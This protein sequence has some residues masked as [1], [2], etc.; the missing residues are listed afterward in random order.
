MIKSFPK[1]LGGRVRLMVTGGAPTP[2]ALKRII[3]EILPGSWLSEAYGMVFFS[4]SLFFSS[5]LFS[6]QSPVI[7]LV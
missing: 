5:I 1:K 7:D 3:G 6:L 4:S 2:P